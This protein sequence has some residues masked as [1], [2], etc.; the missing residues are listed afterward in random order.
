TTNQQ[1]D[2]IYNYQIT[3]PGSITIKTLVHENEKQ[4]VSLGGYL[5]VV[6][7]DYQ[8][9]DSPYYHENTGAIKLVADKKSYQPGETAHVLA[10][11]PSEQ[12][13]IL[14]T[15]ERD[16]VLSAW[17]VNAT[18]KTVVLDVPIAKHYAPN[19][20]LSVTFVKD[21]D[22]Y[23][24]DKRLVVPA[25][26]KILNLEIISNKQEYK[27]RET[28]SYT[29]LARDADGAPVPNAEVSLGVVDEAL[30]SVSPD[31]TANIRQQFYGM[32]YNSLETHLSVSYS[33]RGFAGEKPIDLAS[34]KPSYQLA[35]F[36]NE[37]EFA[38][39]T[40]RKE[41][42]DTAF[43]QPNV[44]TG[45]DGR[46]TVRVKLP[47][48]L[49]TWRATARGVTADTKVGVT[50]EMVISRKDVIMR[51][52]T[53]R[54]FTQ[55]D[56]VTLS[57]IVHNY[58][59]EN[60]T[61]QISLSV[62]GARL[63]DPAQ[64][65]VTIPKMGEH[66]IDWKISTSQTGEVRL[67]A[68]ALTNTESDAVELALDV[69]PRGLHEVK[70]DRWT[71]T[72]E[73]AQQE[74]TINLPAN[75]DLNS[76]QLR[77]EATPSIAG[78]LFGALDYLT[79]YPYGCTEQTMS[80]FLPNIIVS[81]TLK[82]FKST[83]IRNSN[84]LKKKVE[85]GRNRLYSY[86]HE[87]GGWGWW[88]SDNSDPFMTAYVIDGLTLAKQAG[89]DVDEERLARGR[90]RLQGMLDALDAGK[91]LDTRA[92]MVYALAESGGAD[93]RHVEKLFAE[94]DKLEPYGRALLALTLSLAKMDQS[95]HEV[96]A[97]IERSA[98]VDNM[99][100]HWES[101]RPPRLD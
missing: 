54:F 43:W 57:G 79:S 74:F 64:Q 96:A 24:S 53:P 39:P 67:L 14:V 60:K 99:T 46:A 91:D 49:T 1:G 28:A 29:I 15:V 82:E 32:R 84:D 23:T 68:K 7:S 16:N 37:G 88:K 33:F 44:V 20:F 65:T 45:R 42:K 12:A 77:I 4:F 63:L 95:A 36:K 56:T 83:S 71:T 40:I 90:E 50:R 66:R 86:Q 25:R 94:R 41:F 27:P 97:E 5:W 75:A 19:V 98:R 3:T 8:W 80:S 35:D 30:Y 55:G 93:T 17:K 26:D 61:T 70:S 6:S 78:T 11:L 38:Q 72:D 2:A 89:Y 34:T 13:N 22:M 9:M 92:F 31:Y 52:E 59:K 58:L 100:A 10:I 81:Q 69:V 73:N 51:L 21:G 18:G 76:R 48:N 62:S 87:D 85:R 101:K 47:D